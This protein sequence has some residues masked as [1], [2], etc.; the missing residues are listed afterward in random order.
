MKTS[1]FLKNPL[2][3]GTLLMTS[4]GVISRIIGFFYRIFLSRTIGAEA[5]G[6]YQ[7]ISPVVALC[8]ALTASSIQTSISKFVGDAA[9]KCK[10]DLC[11]ERKARAYLYLGLLLSCGL[12]MITGI[13]IYRNADWIAVNILG[14]AR[15]APL[16]ILLTYS[17]LPSCIHACINGYYYGKQ[18]ALVPSVCQLIEQLGRVG[19]VWLIYQVLLEQGKTM[20][21]WHAFC[22]IVIG[23]CFGL[24][25]GLIAYATER[26]IP[27]RSYLELKDSMRP[28][29]CTLGAMVLP[30]TANR[31]LLSMSA[32]LENLLIPQKL[33]DFG[34]SS[35]NAL[36]V[37]GVLSGM[38]MSIIFFP[39]VL[40]NSF[41]VLLL[42]AISEAKAQNNTQ[43]IRAAIQRAVVYGLLLGLV[44]TV[45]FLLLGDWFGNRLF[46]NALAGSFIKRLSF[47]CPLM[48]ITSLLNS[49]MHGLGM[50]KK[51]LGVNLLACLIRI[52]MIW[53]LVPGEGIGAYLW[54]MLISQVF[55]AIACVFLLRNPQ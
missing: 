17:L 48:Y 44:F 55:A 19:S 35:G 1:K 36:A 18:R 30:L 47:L 46:H 32:S 22:G 38:T 12:S 5:L 3:A 37:Y 33:Q 10:T 45:I 49:I 27:P 28:M 53:F 26:R 54:S 40:T 34:Y 51:V 39:G 25:V 15:C 13:V 52:G 20:T 31:V 42:P 29:M 4:A 2:I 21:E 6:I 41:S 23:E 43:K 16:L 7:L 24:V 11:G 50:A 9:G 8:F 14:E